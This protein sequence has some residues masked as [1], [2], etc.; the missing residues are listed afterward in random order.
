M[1]KRLISLLLTLVML[2]SLCATFTVSASADAQV[3]T[4][5]LN[6][7]DTVLSLC[8]KLGVDYYTHK[9]LIMKLNGFTTEGQ[10]SK[11]AVGAQVV[12][13][14]SNAAA[15]ALAGSG[16]TTGTTTATTVTG[17]AAGTT[18]ISGTTTSIPA[19]DYV[20]YY[21]VAYTIQPGETIAGIYNNW[22]L[23]YKTYGT[24]WT[25]L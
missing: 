21:L 25:I 17:T 16:V 19:G 1:K 3:T 8:Q 6:K 13:P 24:V 20:S 23:S 2:V 9:N 15:S 7:G 10:F 14:I 4:V 5:T 22:G 18:T 11:M 12:L